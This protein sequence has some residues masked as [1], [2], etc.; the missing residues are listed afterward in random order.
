MVFLG[1]LCR[2]ILAVIF[3]SIVIVFVSIALLLLPWRWVWEE[4]VTRWSKIVLKILC[5]KVK[6]IGT[7]NLSAPAIFIMN[8]TSIADIMTF[9]LVTPKRSVILAKK[10]VRRVPFITK[11]LSFGGGIFV[12][13]S[14]P[15]KAIADI[16]SGLKRLPK[17][18][19][20]LVFPEGTRS[21]DFQLLAFKKGTAH[22]AIETRLPVV[23]IGHVGTE[24][25]GGGKTLLLNTGTIYM[26]AGAPIDASQWASDK[27][28]EHTKELRESIIAQMGL[29]RSLQDS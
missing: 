5:I 1:K 14:D 25:I 7:E 3:S 20:I 15:S 21:R 9:F 22:M 16:R 24:N 19:S 12:D 6:I 26:S 23:P 2:F 18:Y 4:S 11:I 17:G 29:A 13:R 28:E 8:H 27:V 10:E